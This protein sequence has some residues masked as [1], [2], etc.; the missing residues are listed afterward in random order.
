M[1]AWNMTPKGRAHRRRVARL[2]IMLS[3]AGEACALAHYGM[4]ADYIGAYLIASAWA[5]DSLRKMLSGVWGRLQVLLRM[6]PLYEV[7]CG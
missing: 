5:K 4:H 3:V 2:V 6:A 1:N 7:A